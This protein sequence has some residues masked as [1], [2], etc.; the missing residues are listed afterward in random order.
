MT[1]GAGIEIVESPEFGPILKCRDADVA[2]QFEDFLTEKCFVLFKIK[3]DPEEVSFLF[4]QTSSVSRVR[5][6]YERFQR[7]GMGKVSG[8]I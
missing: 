1:T 2:D 4:G 3:F 8:T 5:E 7:E 6:L